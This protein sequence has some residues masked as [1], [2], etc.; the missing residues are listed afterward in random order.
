VTLF[1]WGIFLCALGVTF[2]FW[3]AIMFN[4]ADKCLTFARNT[5]ANTAELLEECKVTL[6]KAEKLEASP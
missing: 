4:R 6:A 1:I 5:N 3:S 2:L